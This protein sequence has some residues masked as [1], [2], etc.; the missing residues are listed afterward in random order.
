MFNPD[1]YDDD[2]DADLRLDAQHQ[3]RYRAK[4]S[5]HPHCDDPAHPG[6]SACSEPEDST[7]TEEDE[8]AHP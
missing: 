4:L 7:T 2:D 3:R 8:D 6:C 1:F 5:A